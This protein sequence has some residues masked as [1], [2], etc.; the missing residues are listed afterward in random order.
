MAAAPS[1]SDFVEL[2]PPPYHRLDAYDRAKPP[3]NQEQESADPTKHVPQTFIDAMLVRE[4]VF[5]QE[6]KVP[7]ENEY[8]E[9]DR[10]SFH[11]VAYASMPSKPGSGSGS[12][13]VPIGTIRLVPAPN[14]PHPENDQGVGDQGKESYVKLGRLA[15]LKDFRKMG[16]STLLVRKALDHVAVNPSEVRL[17]LDAAER[18]EYLQKN[19]ALE[20]QGLVLVHAQVGVQKVWAKYGFERDDTLGIWDEEGIDHVGMWKRVETSKSKD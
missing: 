14:P 6:Q 12:T 18:E 2:L 20:F 16:I 11:W 17:Q 13:R 9:D 5:V 3:G 19:S 4:E 1:R 15:V 7:L 10:R 8:D